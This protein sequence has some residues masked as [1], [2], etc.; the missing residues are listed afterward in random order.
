MTVKDIAAG[1]RRVQSLL[2]AGGLFSAFAA[3]SCCI[4]PA[5]LLGLGG[6]GAWVG[7]VTRLAPYQPYF[8]AA[9]LLFL[10]AGYRL[11]Y[12]SSFAAADSDACDPPQTNRWGIMTILVVATVLVILALG[13]V[14]ARIVG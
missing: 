3:S 2:A 8:I 9:S 11:T 4:L 7:N 1:S 5:V 10:G 14:L 12:R 6:G 13:D